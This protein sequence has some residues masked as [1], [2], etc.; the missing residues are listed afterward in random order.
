MG[1]LDFLSPKKKIEERKNKLIEELNLFTEQIKA[2]KSLIP[3]TTVVL[4][5]KG[6]KAYLEGNTT[7][8]ETRA[9]RY[10]T[11]GG[12]GF[13]VMKGVYVGG[14]SGTS[15]SK[16]EWRVI[17]KGILTLTNERLIFDGDKED[18]VIPLKKI[19]SVKTSL[20]SI[21]I[22]AETRKKSMLFTLNNPLIWATVIQVL[23]KSGGNLVQIDD[24]KI[25][26]LSEK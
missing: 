21:E 8:L 9:I 1:F 26:I 11:R 3:I 4:L 14:A 16:D 17:D 23:I 2:R 13:R 18:R 5:R 12:M 6:E 22:S 20:D 10:H 19:I 7:L 25:N 24:V 15:E